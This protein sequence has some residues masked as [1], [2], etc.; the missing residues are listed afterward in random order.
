VG[1]NRAGAVELW[2][3]AAERILGWNAEEVLGGPPPLELPPPDAPY[4][5]AEYQERRKDG[6]PVALEIRTAPWLD[7]AGKPRGVL[8][9][10]ADVPASHAPAAPDRRFRELLE[11]APD[12]IVE[13]D[14]DG[15]ILLLNRVTEQIFGYRREELLGKPVEV[16][17]PEHLREGHTGHRAHY[18]AHPQTRPMGA[19]LTLEGRRKDGSRFPAEISLSPVK[20]EDGFRVTAVVRDVSE[21]RRTEQELQVAQAR[22]SAELAGKNRELE[23]RNRE[24]ERANRLKTEFLTGMSH[25]LRTPLHTVIGFA[26]LLAEEL[27]GPLTPKQKRFVSHIQNDA[28]HLLELINDLLDLSKIEAGRLELHRETFRLGDAL[29]EAA[30]QVRP[31]GQAKSI[32]IEVRAGAAADLYADQIRFKQILYNLLSNAVKFTPE[33]GRVWVEVILAPAAAEISVVD[34]GVGI[35]ADEHQA[36]FD[37]FYQVSSGTKGSRQGTGLGLAITRRLVE[38]H[39]GSIRLESAPGQGS[40]F[41][42][43]MPLATGAQAAG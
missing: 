32:G 29:E 31:Q 20:S 15:R 23:A 2:S 28:T 27:Q 41:T 6:T 4:G 42:I 7:A 9:V 5:E 18:W 14:R 37:K 21:R 8:A 34:T 26:E 17:I 24:V 3:P 19:G 36:V 11:A 12:A 43:T 13:V 39:G 35:P 10:I 33:G 1:V 22:Y 30:A 16:L 25:E 38:E 40:R